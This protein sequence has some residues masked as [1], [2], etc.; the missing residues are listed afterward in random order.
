MLP[1]SSWFFYL[2]NFDDASRG[3]PRVSGIGIFICD[4]HRNVCAIKYHSHGTNNIAK[5]TPLLHGLVLA[6]RGGFPKI[7]IKGDS[8]VIINACTKY[9]WLVVN[10]STFSNRYES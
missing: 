3:N 6:K 5:A 4:H 7:H 2:I 8:M 10:L 1:A 9:P